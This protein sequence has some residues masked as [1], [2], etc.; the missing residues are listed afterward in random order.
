MQT[1]PLTWQTRATG[2]VMSQKTEQNPTPQGALPVPLVIP[3][4]HMQGVG[5]L[6]AV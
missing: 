5:L 2:G 6:L 3:A 1:Q 4:A